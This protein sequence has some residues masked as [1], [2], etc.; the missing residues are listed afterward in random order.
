MLVK[1]EALWQHP[2][3][4]LL[5]AIIAVCSKRVLGSLLAMPS[6]NRMLGIVW[7]E[8]PTH[9]NLDR[10]LEEYIRA[11]GIAE[12]RKAPLFRTTRGPIR[13]ADRQFPGPIGCVEDDS[14]KSSRGRYKNRDR[15]SYLSQ[16]V[17]KGVPR[18]QHEIGV[19]W[20]SNSL[21]NAILSTSV[22]T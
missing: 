9:H 15:L 5:T 8:M 14:P 7:H 19:A 22:K 18:Y 12:E 13:R 20:T 10:Y 21:H 1:E 16:L 3:L 17:Y 11:A 4:L 2:K 6:V